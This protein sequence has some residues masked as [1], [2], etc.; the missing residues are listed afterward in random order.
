MRSRPG[1]E[2]GADY[3]AGIRYPI[4]VKLPPP[5]PRAG[6]VRLQPGAPAAALQKGSTHGQHFPRQ[7]R[8]SQHPVRG[9][10]WQAEDD[11][12]RQGQP[13]SGRDDQGQGRGP[14]RFRESRLAGGQRDGR[15][16]SEDRRRPGRQ[17]GRGRIDPGQGAPLARPSASSSTP[18]RRTGPTWG[19]ARKQ[20]TVSSATASSPSSGRTAG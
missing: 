8:Q 11:P 19:A 17:V 13:P 10:R 9:R 1:R 16:V 4:C 6:A 12:A 20:I 3:C 5:L 2:P 14:G 18:T 15:M 7:F